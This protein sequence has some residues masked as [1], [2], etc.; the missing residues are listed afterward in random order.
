MWRKRM[1]ETE[2]AWGVMTAGLKEPLSGEETAELLEFV[3][4]QNSDG[5]W[6]RSGTVP[7]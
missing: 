4:G 7:N 5:L 2:M 6:R 1:E 3:T